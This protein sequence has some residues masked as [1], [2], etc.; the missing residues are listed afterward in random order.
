MIFKAFLPYIYGAAGV[1]AVGTGGYVITTTLTEEPQTVIERPAAEQKPLEQEVAKL[2]DKEPDNKPIVEVAPREEKKPEIVAAPS[3]PT[4]SLIRVEPDGSTVV[5]GSGPKNSKIDLLSGE[6]TLQSGDVG[7]DGDFVIVLDNPLEPGPH[8]L[9][10]VAFLENGEKLYSKQSG[11]IQVAARQDN[12]QPLVLIA[13]P[14]EA[15]RVISKPEWFVRAEE[16]KAE[17]LAA[18]TKQ[19]EAKEKVELASAQEKVEL[20]PQPQEIALEPVLI[21]AVDVENGKIFIAGVGAKFHKVRLYINNEYLGSA[22]ISGNKA[23]LFEQERDLDAGSY[24]VRADMTKANSAKVLSRVE[25][26]LL[27]EPQEQ[28]KEQVVAETKPT[29]TEETKEVVDEKQVASLESRLAPVET[30]Q[31]E[32]EKTEDEIAEPQVDAN[33]RRIIKS[34]ASVIIRRGDSLWY[35]ASKSFGQG[36]RYT[37]I[38]EA[39]R[40]LIRNPN[41]I[42]PGQV[43]KIPNEG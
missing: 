7:P 24:G 31:E 9:R 5:A 14:G 33:G 32:P 10:L 17:E 41:L 6:E 19:A 15:S 25:V 40:N 35:L 27:H 13:E 22:E 18:A 36:V 2:I 1:A 28:P 30:P 8:E 42:F 20:A 12:Q 38:F 16:K 29:I 26:T 3:N 4:F 34:G 43:L 37:T 39:N 23:F 21:E 11:L